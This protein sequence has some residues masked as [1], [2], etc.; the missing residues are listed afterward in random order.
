MSISFDGMRNVFFR[1][2][3]EHDRKVACNELGARGH[4]GRTAYNDEPFDL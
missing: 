3:K 2:G 4:C 1:V